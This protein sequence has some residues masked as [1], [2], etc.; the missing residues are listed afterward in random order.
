MNEWL[1]E[2]AARIA[3]AAGGEPGDYALSEVEAE[4]LLRLAREVAHE[5]GDRRN[6]PLATY[7]AGLAR[8]RNPDLA[9]GVAVDVLAPRA[10]P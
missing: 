10:D 8:G 2:A 6:A 9:T 3:S 1:D 4:M 7:L 5:S